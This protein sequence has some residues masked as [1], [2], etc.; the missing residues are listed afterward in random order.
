MSKIREM[1]LQQN[2][3]GN[4]GN[5]R[6]QNSHFNIQPSSDVSLL[7]NNSWSIYCITIS[8]V[9]KQGIRDVVKKKKGYTENSFWIL[10]LLPGNTNCVSLST[11]F[12]DSSY[13]QFP[14]NQWSKLLHSKQ[15][16]IFRHFLDQLL[17]LDSTIYCLKQ[18]S[19]VIQHPFCCASVM[20]ELLPAVCTML[21]VSFYFAFIHQCNSDPCTQCFSHNCSCN[22]SCSLMQ[23]QSPPIPFPALCLF[24]YTTSFVILTAFFRVPYVFGKYHPFPSQ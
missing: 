7:S 17:P 1:L 13:F 11:S 18:I 16:K 4:T 15:L 14:V 9:S 21:A 24:P 6:K 10:S 8:T 23:V 3:D 5:T 22:S 12:D 2:D 19:I 20:W